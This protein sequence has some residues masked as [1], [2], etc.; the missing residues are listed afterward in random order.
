M[1]QPK[2]AGNLR[3]VYTLLLQSSGKP[4]MWVWPWSQEPQGGGKEVTK[5]VQF[6]SC[7]M[8]CSVKLHSRFFTTAVSPGRINEAGSWI[9][10]NAYKTIKKSW[11]CKLLGQLLFVIYPKPG[12]C[13]T[14]NFKLRPLVYILPYF[15]YDQKL[16]SW[17]LLRM[18]SLKAQITDYH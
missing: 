3:L 11:F 10:K 2:H 4:E 18:T 13:K 14:G 16:T 15:N 8:L 7:G 9:F 12:I 17:V 6:L 1:S 5:T